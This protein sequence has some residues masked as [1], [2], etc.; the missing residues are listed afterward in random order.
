MRRLAV[1]G[2]RNSQYPMH[3]AL[4][5]SLALLSPP[6]DAEWIASDHAGLAA[7]V[8]AVDGLWGAPGFPYRDDEAVL[9]AIRT[10]R[11]RGIPLVG[12]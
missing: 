4:D 9:G 10:A 12:T 6:V 1:V 7:L 8:E 3:R 11:E 5:A 2:D